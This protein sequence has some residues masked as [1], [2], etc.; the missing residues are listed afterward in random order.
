MKAEDPAST[1]KSRIRGRIPQARSANVA[2]RILD[3]SSQPTVAG[4]LP[5]SVVVP[6]TGFCTALSP[7]STAPTEVMGPDFPLD[8]S[9][10]ANTSGAA[11]KYPRHASRI[12]PERLQVPPPAS[13]CCWLLRTA[14][15]RLCAYS[16][17]KNGGKNGGSVQRRRRPAA[18]ANC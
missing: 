11:L 7:C 14:Y 13:A 4:L 1:A 6:P 15:W 18:V 9:F 16:R 3:T 12:S 8:P 17:S 10:Q 5:Q 2:D